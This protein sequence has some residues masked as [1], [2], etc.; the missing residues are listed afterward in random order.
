M[1][2]PVHWDAA[3]WDTENKFDYESYH[4]VAT[5]LAKDLKREVGQSVHVECEELL[6]VLT[7]GTTQSCRPRLGLVE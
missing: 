7:D 1:A 2:E 4:C 5:E 3:P 6:E